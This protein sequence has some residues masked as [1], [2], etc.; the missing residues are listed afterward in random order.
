MNS[1]LP[2]RW[3]HGK[4][5]QIILAMCS[6]RLEKF[7]PCWSWKQ[8]PLLVQNF[9][10]SGASEISWK[11]SLTYMCTFFFGVYVGWMWQLFLSFAVRQKDGTNDN[12]NWVLFTTFLFLPFL[13]FSFQDKI[14]LLHLW[15]HWTSLQYL[16]EEKPLRDVILWV[17]AFWFSCIYLHFHKTFL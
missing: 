15:G 4:G 11:M 6:L 14:L 12:R 17:G 2:R 5:K 1:P 3:L 16:L 7:H 8:N 10:T 13:S 9:R